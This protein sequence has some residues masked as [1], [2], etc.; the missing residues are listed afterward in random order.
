MGALLALLWRPRML[1]VSEVLNYLG[2][3]LIFFFLFFFF[4]QILITRKPS[5]INLCVC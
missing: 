2:R 4:L 5:I 1:S 3:V